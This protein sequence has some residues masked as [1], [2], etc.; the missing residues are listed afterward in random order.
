MEEAKGARVHYLACFSVCWWKLPVE[1]RHT[2]VPMC[3]HSPNLPDL[4]LIMN[5]ALMSSFFCWNVHFN[6]LFLFVN[7]RCALATYSFLDYKSTCFWCRLA[8]LDFH[9]HSF[10]SMFGSFHPPFKNPIRDFRLNF[11]ASLCF[12][13]KTLISCG[14][15]E[16]RFNGFVDPMFFHQWKS[17]EFQ[18]L[19]LM[20]QLLRICFTSPSHICWKWNIP[21]FVGWCE[22][23]GHRN[24][25]LNFL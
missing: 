10:D 7:P 24:Q 23:L 14:E 22:T 2:S 4:W 25:P 17:Q 12:M 8:S 18:G 6:H 19:G 21:F 3:D 11:A 16:S 15:I 1:I 9:I 5:F 13:R 20:S